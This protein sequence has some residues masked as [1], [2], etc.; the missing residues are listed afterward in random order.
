[1]LS[2]SKAYGFSFCCLVAVTTL[3]LG[4]SV[5]AVT[6]AAPRVTAE[7]GFDPPVDRDLRYRWTR[8]VRDGDK[9]RTS[10]ATYSLR[11]APNG[12]NYRLVLKELEGGQKDLRPS[13]AAALERLR[14]LTDRPMIL[15]VDA[16]G[17]IT[18]MDDAETY[19]SSIFS[20][21]R[22][23]LGKETKDEESKQAFETFLRT[24]EGMSVGA[25]L[26]MLTQ[27][28]QPITEFGATSTEAGKPIT[29]SFASETPFGVSATQKATINLLARTET[30]AT[31][32]IKTTLPE[33]ELRK[34]MSAVATTI[35]SGGKTKVP[36]SATL[37]FDRYVQES[38][39]TYRVALG[40][41]LV[42]DF[43]EV[44]FIEVAADGETTRREEVRTLTQ[45]E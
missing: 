26:S 42:R 16:Q 20:T 1:M 22:E 8:E 37:R 32:Q 44:K 28:I 2:I 15:D 35:R 6:T 5:A 12:E 14:H 45:I 33:A 23:E 13:T 4:S 36:D 39:A 38:T 11:F 31:I 29:T 24:F 30:E 10:W 7:I 27:N 18:G 43:R 41:G 9:V 19:W 34:I 17:V 21:L 40:S 3:S 25:R